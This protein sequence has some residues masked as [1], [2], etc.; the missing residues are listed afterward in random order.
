MSLLN[1][2]SVWGFRSGY[3]KRYFLIAF[4]CLMILVVVYSSDGDGFRKD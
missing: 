2:G 4:N 3:D 1:K